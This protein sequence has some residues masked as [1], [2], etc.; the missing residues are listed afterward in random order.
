M[1]WVLA[2]QAGQLRT[3]QERIT[4]LQR[5]ALASQVTTARS[6]TMGVLSLLAARSVYVDHG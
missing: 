3:A 2:E 6:V 4:A 5:V 1:S